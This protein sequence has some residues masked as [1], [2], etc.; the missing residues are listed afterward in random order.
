VKRINTGIL[1]VAALA[2]GPAFGGQGAAGQNA[3][4]DRDAVEAAVRDYVEALYD[5][6]PAKIERSVHRDLV[7]R[8]FFHGGAA[9]AA[10]ILDPALEAVRTRLEEVI[11][12][13]VPSV[14]VAVARDGVVLWEEGFGWMQPPRSASSFVR[15]KRDPET[16]E[17]A[18][19]P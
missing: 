8:G 7:K 15:L 5:V 19:R 6:E 12:G 11:E 14:V 10:A 2:V 16:D 13:G 4:G 9:A 3:A 17:P 1:T 18:R